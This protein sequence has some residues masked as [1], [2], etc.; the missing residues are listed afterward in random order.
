MRFLLEVRNLFVSAQTGSGNGKIIDDVGFSVKQGEL[1]VLLGES[2]SGKTV[3]S[4]SLTGLFPDKSGLHVTGSVNF[5]GNSILSATPEEL[6]ELRRRKIRYIFQEPAQALNPVATIRSQLMLS[7]EKDQFTPKVLHSALTS[8]GLHNVDEVLDSYPHQLSIG[9]AQRVMIATAMLASPA[10]LIADEPTSSVDASLRYELLDLLTSIQKTKGMSM[11]LI[12]HDLDVAQLYGEYILLLYKGRI[13]ESGPKNEF[14]TR[15]LHPYAQLLLDSRPTIGKSV[16]SQSS[17][18][19]PP[20]KLAKHHSGCRFY[21]RC[22]KAQDDCAL[23]EPPLEKTPG[24]REV[25]CFYWR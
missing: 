5:D 23:T 9:M 17:Y 14:F 12:T 21:S 25:R 18:E 1:V 13:V 16:G 15:P 19:S 11:I 10:L 22:P 8:V 20:A 2:G 3:L 4:R 7:S 6:L 24:G